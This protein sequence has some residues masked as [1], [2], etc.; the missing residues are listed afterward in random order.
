[1]SCCE[2][3]YRNIKTIFSPYQ[4]LILL[5][6]VSTDSNS[7]NE[8]SRDVDVVKLLVTIGAET[9]EDKNFETAAKTVG[10]IFGFGPVF[11]DMT[12]VW[13]RSAAAIEDDRAKICDEISSALMRQ[14]ELEVEVRKVVEAHPGV[15]LNGPL[16]GMV[17]SKMLKKKFRAL[18][19][20]AISKMVKNFDTH[21]Y[22]SKWS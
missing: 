7:G 6:V 1:M 16:L 3:T 18:Y 10:S 12:K 17:R 4:Q 20:E 21:I 9:A 15:Q 2:D 5:E 13:L 22:F 14:A 8:L 19:I 11:T